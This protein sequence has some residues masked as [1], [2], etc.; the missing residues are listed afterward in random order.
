MKRIILA[1]GSL[2]TTAILIGT[3]SNMAMGQT[4]ASDADCASP[5][6]CQPGITIC[7]YSGGTDVDGGVDVGTSSCQRLPDACAWVLVPC[8]TESDCSETMWSCIS[9]DQAHPEVHICFPRGIDCSDG[10]ACPAT[11]SC[12]DFSGVGQ[13]ELA[14]IW[15]NP[16]TAQFCW[17]DSL[18]GVADKTTR[19]DGYLLPLGGGTEVDGSSKSS[20]A[21]ATVT[22]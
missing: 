4:C 10:Q 15:A 14:T 9:A 2:A 13:P 1:F 19:V 8:Q 5:L 18:R 21:D 6:T 22:R 17:P 3:G 12:L 7:D 11:W 20:D 16:A